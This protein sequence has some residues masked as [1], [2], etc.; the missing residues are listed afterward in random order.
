MKARYLPLAVAISAAAMTTSV[1]AEGPVDGK[2]YG[3]INVS[4]ESADVAGSKSRETSIV[5]NSS[6]L[7]FKGATKLDEQNGLTVTYQLEFEVSPDEGDLGGKSN[8]SATDSSGDTVTIKNVNDHNTIK[9][10]NSFVGLKGSFG[11]ARVGIHDSAF[12]N[13]Q[14]NV[15]QFNDLKGDLK[16]LFN[17]ENRLKNTVYY[18]S[19]KFSGLSFDLSYATPEATDNDQISAAVK[20]ELDG[21]YAALAYDNDVTSKG[22]HYEAYRAAASYKIEALTV[23]AMFQQEDTAKDSENGFLV[24]AAYKIDAATVKAQYGQSDIKAQGKNQWS[25]GADYKLGKPTKVFAFYTMDDQDAANKDNNYVG[26]GLE[27]K[28]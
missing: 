1:M 27:H 18:L 2:V 19:P 6:R 23:G 8:Y 11:E 16:H 4:L 26:L 7:G 22:V 15:D 10:R 3:K 13:A 25:L 28:F 24:S 14:G 17:G 20:F 12:K 21:L 9:Q 5:N